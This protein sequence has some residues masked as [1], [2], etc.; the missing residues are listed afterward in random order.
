VAVRFYLLSMGGGAGA[1]T[2]ADRSYPQVQKLSRLSLPQLRQQYHAEL[3]MLPIWGMH[4]IDHEYGGIMHSPDDDGTVVC[5][6]S[7]KRF[8][9]MSALERLNVLAVSAQRDV[10]RV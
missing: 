8:G 2:T 1:Q 4:G 6:H 5:R 10:R 9:Q 3:G 7:P